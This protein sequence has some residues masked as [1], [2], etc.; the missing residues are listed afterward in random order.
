M[1]FPIVSPV[2]SHFGAPWDVGSALP[3]GPRQR[4]GRP[5]AADDPRHPAPRRAAAG[6]EVH[7]RRGA[8]VKQR[9]ADWWFGTFFSMD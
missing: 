2:F 6:A 7:G 9:M 8:V 1:C 4:L 5:T 3:G